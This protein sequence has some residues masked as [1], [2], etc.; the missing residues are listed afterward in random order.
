MDWKPLEFAEYF[1]FQMVYANCDI[2]L[3]QER[4]EE[5]V[6]RSKCWYENEYLGIFKIYNLHLISDSQLLI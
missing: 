1:G 4:K 3:K 6:T 5:G 2:I